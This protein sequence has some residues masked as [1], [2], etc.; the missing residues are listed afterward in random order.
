MG[1]LSADAIRRSVSSSF[2]M[3]KMQNYAK[4]EGY[5][6]GKIDKFIALTSFSKKKF[7]K[8]GIPER[9]KYIC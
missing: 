1:R 5:L 9:N 4:R 2:A 8:Y 7:I 3:M 6:N